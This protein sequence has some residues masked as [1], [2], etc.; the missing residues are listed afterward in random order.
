MNARFLHTNFNVFDRGKSIQFY[1]DALGLNEIS[2][3]TAP[4]GYWIEILDR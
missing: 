1:R 3:K 4:D 2:R